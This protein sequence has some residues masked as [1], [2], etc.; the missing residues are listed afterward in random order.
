MKKILYFLVALNLF[1]TITFFV[2]HFSEK[3]NLAKESNL[4]NIEDLYERELIQVINND[5][6]GSIAANI[7]VT[8]SDLIAILDRLDTY[9]ERKIGRVLDALNDLDYLNFENDPAIVSV[10]LAE[11]GFH[12]TTNPYEDDIYDYCDMD[13][14]E[15]EKNL[16]DGYTY[17]E[18]RWQ[19]WLNYQGGRD[20]VQDLGD[21][22]EWFGPFYIASTRDE[23]MIG[24]T[25]IEVID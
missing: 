21:V 24:S 6:S 17:H 10:I 1:G 7:E 11:S 18:C 12:K 19:F 9:Y 3:D 5:F 8:Q 23:D 4:I 25:F 14:V 13:I 15:V 2:S 20:W 22:D 16:P